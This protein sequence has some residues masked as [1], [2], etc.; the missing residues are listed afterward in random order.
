[1][2]IKQPELLG[3]KTYDLSFC[4]PRRQNRK[5]GALERTQAQMAQDFEFQEVKTVKKALAFLICE[6]RE[7]RLCDSDY[8]HCES[9]KS[10]MEWR[11]KDAESEQ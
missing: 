8:E 1:M 6:S 10:E 11:I 3:R 7:C 9:V 5:L 2:R 4:G